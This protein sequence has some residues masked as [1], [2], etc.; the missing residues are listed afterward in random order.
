MTY[1]KI[2]TQIVLLSVTMP[3]DVLKVTRKFRRELI[4]VLIKKGDLVL[5]GIC[6]FYME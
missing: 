1:F 2:N 5:G 6:Q 4:H 3:S